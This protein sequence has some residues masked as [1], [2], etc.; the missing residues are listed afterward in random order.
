M[1]ISAVVAPVKRTLCLQKEFGAAPFFQRLPQQLLAGACAVYRR[2]INI[3]DSKLSGQI[4][5]L[6]KICHVYGFVRPYRSPA[7]APSA[8]RYYGSLQVGFSQ[9]LIFHLH[10]PQLS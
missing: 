9:L 8:K 7:N 5:Q 10:I 6:F 1:E 4:Q 3:I 2:C